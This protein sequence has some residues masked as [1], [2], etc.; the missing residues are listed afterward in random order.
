MP[1]RLLLVRP[2]MTRRWPAVAGASSGT[3]RAALTDSEVPS[4]KNSS[5]V[6]GTTG[7]ALSPY[8]M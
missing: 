3:R 5:H 6:F 1:T 8:P 2:V 4:S 7:A